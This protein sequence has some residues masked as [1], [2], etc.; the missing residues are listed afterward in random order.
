MMRAGHSSR[1]HAKLKAL[2]WCAAHM[3]TSWEGQEQG[4]ELAG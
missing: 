3:V 4:M 1:G 2:Q